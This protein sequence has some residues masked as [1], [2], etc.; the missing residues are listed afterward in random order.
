MFE[1]SFEEKQVRIDH[2][3]IWVS[4]LERMKWF[5]EKYFGAIAGKMYET[6]NK[7]FQSYFLQIGN[8][9][10]LE[11]MK[12]VD[13]SGIN[14]NSLHSIGFAHVAISLGSRQRVDE[15]TYQLIADGF[16]VLNGPRI[17]GDGYYES[18][19]LDPEGN[20]IEMTE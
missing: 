14:R 17:T 4:D 11:I 10:C 20:R 1:L 9:A 13:I 12:R 3:A 6:P 18:A 2:I 16:T 5:Y 19:I 15:M 8:D 7:G